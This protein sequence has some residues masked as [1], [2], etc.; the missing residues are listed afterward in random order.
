MTVRIPGLWW[1]LLG[2]L[3]IAFVVLKLTN[4]ITW[5]WWLVL[6]PM[7]GPI[8]LVIVLIVGFVVLYALANGNLTRKGR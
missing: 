3:T 4:V 2:L 5:S 1:F 8:A 7:W 6:L